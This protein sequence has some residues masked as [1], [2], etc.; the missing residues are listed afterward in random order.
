MSEHNIGGNRF[1]ENLDRMST[2]KLRE[3]LRRDCLMPEDKSEK[4]SD[5]VILHIAEV[6][7]KREKEQ[8]I[9]DTTDVGTAWKA[10]TEHYLPYA[11][12]DTALFDFGD[13][14]DESGSD[15]QS[16]SSAQIIQLH[17]TKIRRGLFRVSVKALVEELSCSREVALVCEDLAEDQL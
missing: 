8:S 5:D 4:L 7:A 9:R 16:A 13:N 15:S 3:M 14:E 1:Y 12:D 6:V 17:P 11:D 10:F 2:E